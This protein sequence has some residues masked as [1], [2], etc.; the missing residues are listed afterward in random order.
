M[1]KVYI[2]QVVFQKINYSKSNYFVLFNFILQFSTIF[3]VE[4]VTR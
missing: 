4:T 3:T 2:E 1:A